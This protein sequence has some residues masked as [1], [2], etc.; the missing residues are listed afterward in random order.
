MTQ[1]A[2]SRQ[3]DPTL[4]NMVI[5][6]IHETKTGVNVL[7]DIVCKGHDGQQSLLARISILERSERDCDER[8]SELEK[9]QIQFKIEDQKLKRNFLYILIV[10]IIGWLTAIVT[11]VSSG[12][13]IKWLI[14][15]LK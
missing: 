8:V 2:K 6:S 10:S 5:E 7:Y 9:F 13:K 1:N 15:L 4:L 14:D 3:D 12:D 11:N